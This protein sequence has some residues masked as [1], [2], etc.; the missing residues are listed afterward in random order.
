MAYTCDTCCGTHFQT[1]E[2]FFYCKQCGTQS[3]QQQVEMESDA[4]KIGD[5]TIGGEV[6]H[7]QKASQ[8]HAR[9]TSWE[10]YNYIL[11]G[12]VDEVIS[13]GA[14]FRVK[15]VVLKLWARYLQTTE[16][17]FFSLHDECLPRLPA[18]YQKRD[19]EIL[20]NK[21]HKKRRRRRSSC[22]SVDTAE[23][24]TSTG[25]AESVIKSFKISKILKKTKVIPSVSSLRSPN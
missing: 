12:L 13:L 15:K 11:I 19:A 25:K 2:G 9:I 5:R 14:N 24:K 23:S 20:Y 1:V 3:Q 18:N 7:L 6:I 17:A 8:E 16:A 4:I 10:E 22:S 21:N